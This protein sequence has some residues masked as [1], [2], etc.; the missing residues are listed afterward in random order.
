MF[1]SDVSYWCMIVLPLIRVSTKL[2]DKL[3]SNSQWTWSWLEVEGVIF[4]MDGWDICSGKHLGMGIQGKCHDW[5]LTERL[6]YIYWQIYLDYQDLFL[7]SYVEEEPQSFLWT[8]NWFFFHSNV[9]YLHISQL[10][11]FY[12]F[13]F[14]SSP[15]RSFHVLLPHNNLLAI[16]A[17]LIKPTSLI[18][19]SY[20]FFITFSNIL[21]VNCFDFL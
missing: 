2:W 20:Q 6:L 8:T 5:G 9:C 16:R 13:P 21:V 10:I 19:F 11:G 3:Y 1:K 17:V 14:L 15:N 7:C 18:Y 4:G 12:R